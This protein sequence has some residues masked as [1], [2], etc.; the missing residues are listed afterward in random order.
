MNTI[1]LTK[2]HLSTLAQ[3]LNVLPGMRGWDADWGR[4]KTLADPD[5]DP[6]LVLAAQVQGEPAGFVVGTV[7]GGQGWIKALLVRS[8][9]QRQGVG[10]ELLRA[11]EDRFAQRG[12]T[13]VIVGWAPLSYITPGVDVRFTAATAFLERHGYCTD[14]VSRVNLDVTLAGRDFGT[15]EAEKRLAAERI[16]V[17]RAKLTDM[18]AIGQLAEAEGCDE[19][20]QAYQNEPVSAFVARRAGQV[21]GFVAHSVSGP[22]EFG[23]MLTAAS[24]RGQGI[25]VALLKRCLADLQRLSY[26]RAEIIWAGPISFY[27]KVVDACCVGRVFWEWKKTTR[28]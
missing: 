23:P 22:G 16:T 12:V 26:R 14:R 19:S 8:D 17:E 21:C 3:W 9:R 25:G 2:H 6:A 27:A 1:P 24:L 7:R 4:R 20:G 11:M 15:V 5:Y 28:P 13:Q 18:E 10:S